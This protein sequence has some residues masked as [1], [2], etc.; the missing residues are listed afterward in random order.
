[1]LRKSPV[2][3]KMYE[4]IVESI[5]LAVVICD[6]RDF[7]ISYVNEMSRRT[8]AEIEHL[9]TVPGERDRRPV[10]RYLPQGPRPPAP[11]PQRPGQPAAQGGD[12]VG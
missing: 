7:R 1:M 4:Q 3:N 8:L 5:P 9:L 6:I 12:P 10:D 2:D 11:D